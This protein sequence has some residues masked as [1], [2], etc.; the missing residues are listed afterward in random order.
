MEALSLSEE[1][2]V[3]QSDLE[4]AIRASELLEA[5]IE[6]YRDP[7]PNPNP[8]LLEAD[9]EAYRELGNKKE[10]LLDEEDL[11]GDLRLALKTV[12]AANEEVE[13]LTEE[14]N[15]A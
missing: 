11:G 4:L 1:V 2:R 14:R 9:L 10:T 5:D 3:L 7:N 12:N 13:A 15:T 8:N 6:A